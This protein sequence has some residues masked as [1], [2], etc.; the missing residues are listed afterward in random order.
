MSILSLGNGES[1]KRIDLNQFQNFTTVGCNAIVRDLKVDH[2]ICVDRRMVKEALEHS[3]CPSNVYTRTNWLKDFK[4]NIKVVQV[5]DLP[6]KGT[7]RWD[8][9]FHWGSGPYA[10]LLAATL[11]DDIHLLGFDLYSNNEFV[12][13]IYKDT[14]NYISSDK[15]S[16]DPKYWI[17]QI[18]KVFELF[19]DKYFTVYNKT[20]W[21]IPK[22]WQLANVKFKDLDSLNKL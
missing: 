13:N 1:R 11:D 15:K 9:P 6:Y 21:Q 12:N 4:Q 7:E 5:P 8:D 10:V 19:P 20:D 18:S 3:N 14:Q 16:V 17:H 2:L 22:Q